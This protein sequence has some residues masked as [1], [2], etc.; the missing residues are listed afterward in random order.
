MATEFDVFKSFPEKDSDWTEEHWKYLVEYLIDT[1]MVKYK[2][3]ASLVLD[4]KS[5]V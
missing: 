2:E 3:L 5:V 1:D 4:R